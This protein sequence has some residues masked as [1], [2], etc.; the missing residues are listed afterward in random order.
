M[1]RITK[2]AGF[3]PFA[4]LATCLIGLSCAG[5]ADSPSKTDK[6]TKDKPDSKPIGK[7]ESKDAPAASAT[8]AD[9]D[10]TKKEESPDDWAKRVQMLGARGE[11]NFADEKAAFVKANP[12]HPA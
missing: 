10:K 8:A 11:D 5:G 6:Q 9:D 4:L 3:Y 1:L 7:V 2:N 12:D